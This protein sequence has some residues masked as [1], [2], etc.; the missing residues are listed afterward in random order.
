MNGENLWNTILKTVFAMPGIKVNRYEFLNSVLADYCNRQRLDMLKELRPYSIVSDEVI[1]AVAAQTINRH[2]MLATA[3]STIAGLPGG[4]AMAATIPGDLTQY[5]FH[6]IV[7]AQKLAYLY[8]FPDF[9]DEEGHLGDSAIDMLTIFVGSMM[10]VKVADQGISQIARGLATSAVGRLPRLA[11]AKATLVP[12]VTQV[13][14]LMGMKLS[15][16]GLG[17]TIGKFIPVVGGVFSGTLTLVTFKPGAER[18]RRRLKAQKMHFTCDDIAEVNY[19]DVKA[20]FVKAE[21][22]QGHV[23]DVETAVCQAMINMANVN[24][25]N[26]TKPTFDFIEHHIANTHLSNNTKLHLLETI[27]IDFSYDVDYELLA[28]DRQ[29]A[30]KALRLVIGVMKADNQVSTAEKLYLTMTAKALGVD[31]A[32]LDALLTL[33]PTNE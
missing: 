23:S 24:A 6:T 26:V 27:D 29:R 20:S 19:A 32:T 16:E 13:A 28:C 1:D 11:I 15:R 14:K 5:Y 3:T 2:T 12:V 22:S 21:Q 10:G 25:G 33:Q 8:G 30:E 4:L 17:R 18:L 31:K 7:L 9:A